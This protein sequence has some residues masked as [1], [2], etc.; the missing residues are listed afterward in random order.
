MKKT[1]KPDHEW[2]ESPEDCLCLVMALIVVMIIM[3]QCTGAWKKSSIPEDYIKET[4]ET[5]YVTVDTRSSSI[6]D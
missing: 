1:E 2:G 4:E 3:A 5:T 6:Q